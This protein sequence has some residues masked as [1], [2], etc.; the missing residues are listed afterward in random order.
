MAAGMIR[1]TALVLG[2]LCSVAVADD[3]ESDHGRA[4]RLRQQ[5]AVLPLEEILGR[6]QLAPG[7]RILEIEGETKH[8]RYLYEIE[9]LGPDGRVREIKVDATDGSVVDED[10]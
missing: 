5:S 2:L 7:S 6:L 1:R 8:G 9:L 10:R 3:E 4:Y